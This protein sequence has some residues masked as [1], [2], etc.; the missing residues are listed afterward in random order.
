ME[1]IYLIKVRT[2][3][4]N[5]LFKIGRTTQHPF[6][7][8]KQYNNDI[9]II[10]VLKVKNCI[11]FEK[12]IITN[13]KKRFTN[14]DKIGNEYFRGNHEE[15]TN[16]LMCIFQ[17][18]NYKPSTQIKETLENKVELFLKEDF[19]FGENAYIPYNTFINK[20]DS[21]LVDNNFK[22]QYRQNKLLTILSGKYICITSEKLK[23]SYTGRSVTG[24]FLKGISLDIDKDKY[25]LRTL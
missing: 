24:K 3:T 15:M 18:N 7:R 10:L 22:T 14:E 12:E 21:F 23:D 25:E 4:E 19:V 5:D 20:F 8:I 2:L 1:Y 17:M 16:V 13:F 9:E 6:K 11:E